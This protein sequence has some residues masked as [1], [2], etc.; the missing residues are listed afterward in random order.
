MEHMCAGDSMS[1]SADRE[2]TRIEVLM[3]AG[4]TDEQVKSSGGM[5][6]AGSIL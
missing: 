4:L 3:E 1:C 2:L 6:C 5:G